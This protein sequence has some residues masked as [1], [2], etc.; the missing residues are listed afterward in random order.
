MTRV[1]RIPL[2]T[3]LSR[4]A[5][6]LRS[7]AGITMVEM[8][9]ATAVFAVIAAPLA[10]VLTSSINSHRD[11]R[12]KTLAQ[13]IALDEIEKIRE[14]D[15]EDVGVEG[16]N[17][18]GELKPSDSIQDLYPTIV[19]LRGT[20]TRAVAYVDD[21]TPTSY[22]TQANYKQVTISIFRASDSKLLTREVT[23][24]APPE[25]APFG[26]INNAIINVNVVDYGD[27]TPVSGALVNLT[28][29]PAGFSARSDTTDSAGL[30]TFAALTPNGTSDYYDIAVSK[31]GYVTLKDDLSPA[32]V[33]HTQVAPSQTFNTAIRVY[34]PATI[35]VILHNFDGSSY[36]G[37]GTVTVSSS[38]GSETF[39]YEGSPLEITSVNG[40][41]VVPSLQYTVSAQTTAGIPSPA[42]T[43]YVPDDY[44]NDLSTDFTVTFPQ[45]GTIVTTVTW[46]GNPVSG[47][48]VSLTGGPQSLSVTGT[49]DSSGQVTFLNVPVGAG[50]N[51]SA[52]H[53]GQSAGPAE[54]TVD[55]G[56]TTSVSLALPLATL[57]VTATWA[58]SN[59]DAASITLSGGPMTISASGTTNSSGQVAFANVPAGPGYTI[60]ATKSGQTAT[61]TNQTVNAP[62]SGITIALPTGSV[63]VTVMWGGSPASNASVTLSGG[64]MSIS[65]SGTTN[66][67]GQVTF[68][69]VPAG[70]GYT[71]SATKSGQ[72]ATATNQSV[73]G[74][75][76]TN[77]SLALSTGT[78]TVTVTWPTATV[79]GATVTL[80][81]GP[82]SI[83]PVSATTNSSGVAT[84]TNAPVG[85]GYTITAVKGSSGTT[86]LTN[87]SV[88][89]PSSSVSMSLPTATLDVTVTWP[90]ATV[91]DATV[92]LSGG[93]MSLS[94]IS[95]T[96]DSSG[97]ATFTNVPVGSGY[98]ITAVKGSSGTT[99]LT[100]QS[101]SAPTT[102]RSISLPTGTLNVNV[103]RSGSNVSG[104]TVTLTLG[105]MSISVSGTTNFSGNVSF[106]NVP[107]GS[108]Y[109]VKAYKCSFSSSR[110]VSN[111]AVT[112]NAG[113]NSL[114]L[115]LSGS[116]CPI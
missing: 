86:T 51:V 21:P 8:L 44:P 107:V 87:Q 68:T 1:P 65:S 17:P 2:L 94:P 76:T 5:S 24:I 45:I 20:I 81:G 38:R 40:E 19:G 72:T 82:N 70:T 80:S 48:T 55:P 110:S 23:N 111:T 33:A 113:S 6:R 114:N 52:T 47:A 115:S 99:T 61:L 103:K 84:F 112:V 28:G 95:A 90:T 27:N 106:T 108:G 16:G 79:S 75:S 60:T 4:A 96:S 56:E 71:V 49:T 31:S 37:T 101:V 12:Q 88:A 9:I 83:S 13:Q 25:R 100:N 32:A 102:N 41:Q 43:Q 116:T 57:T 34:R 42:V 14:M 11:S 50:Y 3:R 30:V 15:Y 73:T 53:S 109:T 91:A 77:V 36:T 18:P 67:S 22:A 54:A 10:T 66:S 93:P 62:T 89:S 26:G 35:N 69:N 64:P 58:G 85:S 39:D 98:T 29:G 63:A 46:G 105:P 78:L 92:T 74:G 104:A 97:I 59:V 7:E